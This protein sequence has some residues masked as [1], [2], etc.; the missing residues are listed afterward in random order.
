MVAL[1]WS[2]HSC[3]HL[4]RKARPSPSRKRTPM[5]MGKRDHIH[6][7]MGMD[8]VAEQWQRIFN[9]FCTEADI[10]T[11]HQ[12]FESQL[13]E[14]IADDADVIPGTIETVTRFR[15]RGMQIGATTGYTRSLMTWAIPEA[16]RRGYSSDWVVCVDEVP[17]VALRRE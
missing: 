14:V 16:K 1:R 10:D 7:M 3:V 11:L 2:P 5:G 17:Q 9:R 13:I 15:T 6:A 8:S 4:K 12:S